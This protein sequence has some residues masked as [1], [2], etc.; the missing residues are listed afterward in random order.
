MLDAGKRK[1]MTISSGQQQLVLDHMIK[2][3]TVEELQNLARETIKRSWYES[4]RKKE[5]DWKRFL[6]STTQVLGIV[7]G[8]ETGE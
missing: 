6:D 1:I 8:Y 2:E 3:L 4:P 5:D 7:G